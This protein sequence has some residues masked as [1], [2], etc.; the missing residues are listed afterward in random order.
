MATAHAHSVKTGTLTGS[1]AEV[2]AEIERSLALLFPA[3][4]VFEVRVLGA[5]GKKKRIDAGYFNNP[6]LAAKAI[7]PYN[8]RASGIYVTLNAINPQLHYRIYNRIKAWADTTTADKDIIRQKVIGIDIDVARAAGISTTDEEHAAA[9]E[10]ANESAGYLKAHGC[11]TV[12]QADSGNGGHLLL[13]VDLPGY[14]PNITR[15]SSLVERFLHALN[16]RFARG[17]LQIVTSVGNLARIWK[18]YGTI[19]AKGDNVPGRPHRT[20]HLLDTPGEKTIVSPDILEAIIADCT[21]LPV[22]DETLVV[23]FPRCTPGGD[24]ERM[25]AW[26]ARHGIA[27]R[28][29]LPY[30]DGWK[31]ERETCP[32]NPDHQA[33]DA[34]VYLRSGGMLGFD[35]QHH[36]CK[37]YHWQDFRRSY[38]PEYAH[39]EQP[40]VAI[41]SAHAEAGTG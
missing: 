15:T 21:P 35:C 5:Y 4:Q 18:C 6:A 26:L 3:E 27:F 30:Q 34:S 38:E 12:V 32:F 31:W 40:L 39:P 14:S 37:Q 41:Q 33:G 7:V 8:G 19:A 22:T 17:M 28:P 29:V 20:A 9:L 36:S 25:E 10:L 16:T 24:K 2:R 1:A 13:F 11:T 23:Q